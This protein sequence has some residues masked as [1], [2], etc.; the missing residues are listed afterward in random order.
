MAAEC[1]AKDIWTDFVDKRNLFIH[2]YITIFS[3]ARK[4]SRNR[5]ALRSALRGA[6]SF[7]HVHYPYQYETLPIV[8]YQKRNRLKMHGMSGFETSNYW[9]DV[10][11][12]KWSASHLVRYRLHQDGGG[13]EFLSP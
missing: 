12:P 2:L 8:I 13:E 4:R 5:S 3:M 10:G 6:V 9:L 11:H 1:Q 7:L